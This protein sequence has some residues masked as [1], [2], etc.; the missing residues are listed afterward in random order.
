M[1]SSNCT[2]L[3]SSYLSK[4]VLMMTREG[5]ETALFLNAVLFQVQSAL[6]FTGALGGLLAAAAIAWLW[7]KYGHRVNLSRFLQVTAI[8]L[9]VFVLQLL[10]YGFHE[11]TEAN[12][13]PYS[14]QLHWATE[15]YGPDGRYGQFLTYLLVLLP[16]GWLVIT[17]QTRRASQERAPVVD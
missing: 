14:E 15:P 8:F 17:A 1:S 9:L 5:M 11:L 3:V 6:V 4:T 13:L 2:T 7:S 12:V 16:L 10:V